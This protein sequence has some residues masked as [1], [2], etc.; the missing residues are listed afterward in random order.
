MLHLR[1]FFLFVIGSFSVSSYGQLNDFIITAEV[2]DEICT[3]N[4]TITLNAV[5]VT[6]GATVVYRL[7]LAPDFTTSISE[8]TGNS[9]SGLAGGN[10]RVVATQSLGDLSNTAT[11]NEVIENLVEDLDFE[12]TDS[13]G[14]DCELTAQLVVNVLSGNA[15]LYEIFQGPVI[16]PLQSS[17]VF[18]DLP[19]GEYIVRVFDEC[20]DALSKSYT[21]VIGSSSI[22]ISPPELPDIYSS[23]TTLE[24]QNQITTSSSAFLYPL[25]VNYTVF[26]PDGS[27]SQNYSQIFTSGD[28]TTINLIQEVTIFGNQLFSIEIEVIDKCNNIAT[29]TFQVNP[30]PKLSIA[31]F[32]D[33]CGRPYFELIITNYLPPF[34]INFTQPSDFNPLLFNT[35]YPGPY[36]SS[37]VPFGDEENTVPFGDYQV[38]AVDSCGRFATLSFSFQELPLE[39]TISAA[40]NGCNSN[41]GSLTISIPNNGEI[42]AISIVSAPPAYQG[43]LPVNVFDS[44]NSN[45]VY[46]GLNL[47][48]GEYGLIVLD[49]CDNEYDII[50]VIPEFV[51]GDVVATTRPSCSAIFGAV[52]L[53]SQN[54]ALTT[55][56][57]IN[58]P[59]SYTQTQTLP[60]NVSS[61]ISGGNFYMTGLPVGSYT[62]NTVDVCGFTSQVDVQIVGYNSISNGFTLNRKCGAFD[63]IMADSDDSITGKTFWF[64]RFYPATNTWG[65]P[66]T[67]APFTEGTI[68][69]TTNS[70]QLINNATLFNI[71]VTGNFRIIKVFDTYNNGSE[72]GKCTD[73]YAEFVVLAELFISGVYNL[74][75]VGG[76]SANDVVL[77]VIGVEPIEYQITQPYF[78]DNGNNN[79]FTNLAP[80]IY[81][82]LATDFCGNIKNIS[83]EISTLLPLARA[84]QPQNLVE[85]RD[86]GVESGT[87][88]LVNQTPQILGNQIPANYLVTYHLTQQDANSGANPLPDGYTNISNP[89]TIYARVEHRSIKLCYATTSF[90]IVVGTV[91]DL[92]P[93]SELFICDGFIKKLEADPG[94]DAYEWSTGA[95]TE[96]IIVNAPGT[97]SVIVKNVYGE[98]SCDA[99]RNFVVTTSGPATID[100]IETSDWSSTNNSA[101]I[102][103]SGKGTYV[104]S[105][106]NINFQTSNTFTNLL[107]GFYTVYV[108]DINGCGTVEGEFALLNYPKYFTPNGDGYND[109]WHIQFSSYEPALNVDIFDRFGKFIIRLKG[110]EGG[111]DGTYNGHEL[112]STDY[113][114]VATR[115]DG[116]IYRG[117]FSLKR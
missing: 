64:Q 48:V 102:I 56:S 49:N 75:C 84:S 17:N 70:I 8:T 21:L 105:L 61:N 90:E 13:S 107:T 115:Q 11:I 31:K 81:N 33:P 111:W 40:N 117:H 6:P 4:G 28:A 77:D 99:T 73:I 24:I 26:A 10:Y 110:G 92:A 96:S 76:M 83:V 43:S 82:I 16:R 53:S 30:N 42:V 58:A 113:W 51:M 97:Y 23:C 44:V 71:F 106:D 19:S 20:G 59:L 94:F 32:Q 101:T 104:Y 27:E 86:D 45:G 15:A 112:F 29:A 7:Y 74:N 2:T 60:F 39:P 18:E 93:D 36:T 52:K 35:Q 69:T 65:H 95:T 50:A 54:G 25:T 5:N 12:I 62:F 34:G 100:A 109:T 89:Q 37:T 57:I 85:C 38:A 46:Q 108:K 72:N 68:P 116:R 14:E 79:V 9:F 3:N 22:S 66:L 98:F 78:L 114:F 88:A 103:V 91:P 1:I 55:V 87:F 63:I 80:G 47:P 41:F 67:A